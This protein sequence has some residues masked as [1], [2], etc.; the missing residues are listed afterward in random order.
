MKTQEGYIKYIRINRELL[1]VYALM[2]AHF[3]LRNRVKG[4]KIT[5]FAVGVI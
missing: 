3:I 1:S 4:Y 5:G 2:E